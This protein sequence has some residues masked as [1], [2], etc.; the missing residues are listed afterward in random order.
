MYELKST[1]CIIGMPGVGKSTLAHALAARFDLKYI[2][3]DGL[4]E[5]DQGKSVSA[6]WKSE[7][8]S[9]FRA[10]ERF[11]LCKVLGKTPVILASGGGTPCYFNNMDLIRTYSI[12]LYLK[13]TIPALTNTMRAG[14]HPV[15]KPDFDLN[16]QWNEILSRRAFYYNQSDWTENVYMFEPNLLESVSKICLAEEIIIHRNL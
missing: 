3:L 16:D 15:F 7:G 14:N 11:Y 6:I 5:L 2:D 10:L 9:F 4:I 8:E 13:S 12:P 1:I